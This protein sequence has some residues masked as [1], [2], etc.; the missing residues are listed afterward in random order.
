MT[1]PH[2]DQLLLD[3]FAAL[4]QHERMILAL[5]AIAGE[6]VGK[7]AVYEHLQRANIVEPDGTPFALLTV[8]GMLQHLTRH[9][10]A[11]EVVGRGYACEAKL[12]WPAMR[13]AIE[14][15]AFRD[16]C[17]AIETINPVRRNWDGYVELRS[18]RQGVARLRIALLR[19]DEV[20]QVAAILA[21]CMACYEAQQLHPLIEIFGRPFEPEM[22]SFVMPQLQDDIL[23][24]LLGN[25]PREPATAHAIRSYA[26]AHHARQAAAGDHIGAALPLALAEDALLCGELDAAARYLAGQQGPQALFV[27]SSIALLRGEHAHAVAGFDT[28]LKGLRKEAG[29]RKLCFTG[30]GGHL[31]VLALLRGNDAKLLKSAETYLDIAL[32]AQPNHDSIVYQQ[33]NTLR[34]VRAGVLLA[35]SIPTRSWETG[36]QAQL[37]QALLYYWLALPQLNERKDQLRLLVQQADA[38]GYDLIAAQAAGLLGLLGEPQQERYATSKRAQHG[39]T[40][41]APWFERQEAWQRQLSALINL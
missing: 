21:A 7:H 10:L 24:V 13:A 9:A 27:D 40:D 26:R 35:E 12:R 36:L 22:L 33:F 11:S 2:L 3:E 28:A 30:I 41:M 37:F 25:A 38:A 14:H 15:L 6:P 20:R 32:H 19:N 5:L 16:L 34:L 23:A 1:D 8:T 18:Y 29:K 39:L 31:Y 17:Q 4:E